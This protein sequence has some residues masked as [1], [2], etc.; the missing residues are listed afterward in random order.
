MRAELELACLRE[1]L[2]LTPSVPRGARLSVNLSAPLL[3]DPRTAELLDGCE[4]PE[5]L[6]VE[7]TEETLVRHDAMAAR[8]TAELREPRDQHR[9]G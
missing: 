2:T 3:A 5:T 7:V 8:A 1:A 9:R 4:E 6:I